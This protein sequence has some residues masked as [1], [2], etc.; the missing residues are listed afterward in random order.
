[1]HN[2][3]MD[4]LIDLEAIR[5]KLRNLSRQEVLRIAGEAQISPSTLQKFRAGIIKE[6][7]FGKVAALIGV[8]SK[9]AADIKTPE[10][11]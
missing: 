11:A 5:L 7:G 1:M 8:M 3:F 9:D 6:P 10:G 2:P 4:T